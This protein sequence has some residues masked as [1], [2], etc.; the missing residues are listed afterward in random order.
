MIAG[1]TI[2]LQIILLVIIYIKTWRNI[3][4]QIHNKRI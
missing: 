3:Y 1:K 4:G 2:G